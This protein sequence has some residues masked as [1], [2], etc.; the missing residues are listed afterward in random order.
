MIMLLNFSLCFS[1]KDTSEIQQ[2]DSLRYQVD[3][4]NSINSASTDS[5]EIKVKIFRAQL[6]DEINELNNTLKILLISFLI[7]AILVVTLI[8]YIIIDKNG[9]RNQ[10]ID[11]ITNDNGNS[12]RLQRWEA[13]LMN[14]TGHGQNQKIFDF[15]RPSTHI[16]SLE[17]RIRTLERMNSSNQ[18]LNIDRQII[19]NDYGSRYR[20]QRTAQYQTNYPEQGQKLYADAIV[21]DRF[22]KVVTT[23]NSDSIYELHLKAA[24]D[25]TA[26]FTLFEGNKKQVLRNADKVDG[27][28]KQRINS[29]PESIQVE[30]GCAILREGRWFITKKA[31][32]K[33]I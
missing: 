31:I 25:T 23:S 14:G 27:C 28:V 20:E 16:S 17:D 6:Q 19:D 12:I 7:L 18:N 22:N 13:K 29:Q 3:N 32:V 30:K 15:D 24:S 10:I 5:V 2:T 11:T 33:F 9:R 26:E 1:N 8:V 21:G 4:S